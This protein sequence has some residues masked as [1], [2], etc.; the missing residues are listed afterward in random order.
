MGLIDKRDVTIALKKI[1]KM[2]HTLILKIFLIIALSLTAVYTAT[3]HRTLSFF[4]KEIIW[5]GLGV[6][7]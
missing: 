7:V 6:F 3:A 4:K 5:T 1:K 2:D